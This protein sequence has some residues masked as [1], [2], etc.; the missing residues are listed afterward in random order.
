M[1]YV[2]GLIV[3]CAVVAGCSHPK[4]VEQQGAAGGKAPKPFFERPQPDA[5]LTEK[6]VVGNYS[7]AVEFGPKANY[8]NKADLAKHYDSLTVAVNPDHSFK[9]VSPGTST[10]TTLGKWRFSKGILYVR[11]VSSNGMSVAQLKAIGRQRH[12][13]SQQLA[14]LDKELPFAASNGG[15]ILTPMATAAPGLHVYYTK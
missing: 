5:S 13:T 3:A 4:T 6:D 1:K 14:A 9:S 12:A 2:V 7:G 15:H 11:L 10:L 8:P